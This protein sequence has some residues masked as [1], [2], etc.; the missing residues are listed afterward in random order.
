MTDAVLFFLIYFLLFVYLPYRIG[1]WIYFYLSP[2]FRFFYTVFTMTLA[3][4]V[5]EHTK[6]IDYGVFIF[7]LAIE[8]I[9]IFLIYIFNI[10]KIFFTYTFDIEKIYF[11]KNLFRKIFAVIGYIVSFIFQIRRVNFLKRSFANKQKEAYEGFKRAYENFQREKSLFEEERRKFFD[12]VAKFKKEKMEFERQK[13]EFESRKKRSFEFEEDEDFS[14]LD[15]YEI[16]GVSRNASKQEIKKAWLKKVSEYHPDKVASLGE[17]LRKLAEIETKKIN[18]A[19]EQ[20][21]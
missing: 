7:S 5:Y 16:L 8:G 13:R 19:W 10:L 11:I 17:K 20:L 3:L 6:N 18:W 9:R 12:E 14:F 15:P 1:R 2:F 21:K 4:N